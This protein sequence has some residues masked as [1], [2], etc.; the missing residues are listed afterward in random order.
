MDIFVEKLEE[1]ELMQKI[2]DYKIQLDFRK[3]IS[4][5]S[6]V[7]TLDE[8][9]ILDKFQ[10]LITT[11]FDNIKEE[12][13]FRSDIEVT[14]I[15]PTF[16][17]NEKIFKIIHS[18]FDNKI[19]VDGEVLI[20]SSE[21]GTSNVILR[22]Y[23][24]DGLEETFPISI[25]NGEAEFNE[26]QSSYLPITQEEYDFSS[27]NDLETMIYDLVDDYMPEIEE[28]EIACFPCEECEKFTINIA[29]YNEFSVGTCLYCKHMNSVGQCTR[30]GEIIDSD[31]DLL[32]YSCECNIIEN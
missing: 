3:K 16:N 14:L 29:E 24:N 22:L 17:K 30:C 1:R 4:E 5:E 26:D 31:E 32:C 7:E 18:Y 2:N 8:E 12:I 11:V 15:K 6:G 10:E 25:T 13:Y 21:G 23:Y 28:D 19:H 20:D 9:E 27:L